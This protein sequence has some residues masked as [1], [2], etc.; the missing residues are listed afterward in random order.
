MIRISPV[1]VT[2]FSGRVH[3]GICRDHGLRA[4]I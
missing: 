2:L 3:S 4:T 1:P